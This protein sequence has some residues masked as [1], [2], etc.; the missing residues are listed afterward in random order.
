MS[1]IL[2]VPKKMAWGRRKLNK[3]QCLSERRRGARIKKCLNVPPL[4]R[5]TDRK[6]TQGGLIKWKKARGFS[7]HTHTKP[8]VGLIEC[9]S[10]FLFCELL[11]LRHDF[12]LTITIE[13]THIHIHCRRE[14]RD[15]FHPTCVRA[16]FN[17]ANLSEELQRRTKKAL[18]AWC[19]QRHM[20]M[21]FSA[22]AYDT[23]K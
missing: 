18:C 5:E 15:I 14:K 23:A 7:A 1:G 19:F 11:L 4:K 17:I 13:I 22:A 20:C 10:E 3:F 9:F 8:C 2:L 16:K 6:H 21:C 12:Y